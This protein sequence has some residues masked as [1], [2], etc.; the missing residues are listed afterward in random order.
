MSSG[1]I[2]TLTARG[3]SSVDDVLSEKPVMKRRTVRDPW[4]DNAR[5]VAAVLICVMHFAGDFLEHSRTLQSLYY[6]TWPWRIPVYVLVAGYFSNAAP[7]SSARAV[8][9][10]R[11]ILFVYIA[12]YSIAWL[13]RGLLYGTWEYN[14]LLPTFALWFLLSLFWWRLTLPVF[15]NVRFLIPVSFGISIVSGFMA[16]AGGDL[17]VSRTLAMWPLFL[18]GWKMRDLALHKLA[19]RLWVRTFAVA[20]TVA[21]FAFFRFADPEIKGRYFS[22]SRGYKGELASQVDEASIRILILGFAILGAFSLFALIPRRKIPVLTYVG[23]GSFYIYLLHP[24]AIRQLNGT[25]TMP[26]VATPADLIVFLLSA[27]LF[28][29]ALGSRP[30]RKVFRPLIQPRYS[31]MFRKS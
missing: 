28:A 8:Q 5:L 12:F 10:L 29:L 20:F 11:N 9:L 22:M 13:Q 18:L 2:S 17:S 16:S 14:P 21:S 6:G 26:E 23:S 30:I 25:G 3:A 27:A 24:L 19:G 7:L 1:G 4:F 31:K 15:V